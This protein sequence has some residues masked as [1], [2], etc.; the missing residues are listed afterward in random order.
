MVIQKEYLYWIVRQTYHKGEIMDTYECKTCGRM[1]VA[2]GHLCDPT[3]A[4]KVYTCEDCG[5]QVSDKKHLCKPRVAKFKYY[6]GYCGRPAVEE[7]EVCN[8]G[9]IA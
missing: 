3:E 5:T 1:A 2:K 6:C 8:P 7:D 4:G 9:P